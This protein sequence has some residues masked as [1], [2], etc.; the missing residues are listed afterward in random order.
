[1]G[2]R[3]ANPLSRYTVTDSGCWEYR[4]ALTTT[5]YARLSIGSRTTGDRRTTYAHRVSYEAAHGPI[6]AGFHIDHL[7]RNHCCINPDHLEAVTPRENTLRGFG[8]ASVNAL[9]THCPRGHEYDTGTTEGWRGCKRCNVQ[10][11]L[12]WFRAHRLGGAP[13]PTQL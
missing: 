6:P 3:I 9:K 11:S 5:G 7:C 10:R 8:P 12:K 4:H 2:R 1:M 13:S